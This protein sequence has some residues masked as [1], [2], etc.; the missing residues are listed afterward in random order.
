MSSRR[1]V[2]FDETPCG[3]PSTPTALSDRNSLSQSKPWRDVDSFDG[4]DQ[5]MDEDV[6]LTDGRAS[7]SAVSSATPPEDECL[8]GT[9][10][11]ACGR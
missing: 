2:S 5:V 4:D 1:R 9:L 10:K 8:E 7:P 6:D 11:C 3:S